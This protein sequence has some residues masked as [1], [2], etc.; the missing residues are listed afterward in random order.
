[1]P[2]QLTMERCYRGV[3]G[4]T[5]GTSRNNVDALAQ[6][7]DARLRA[8]K[9]GRPRA[10]RALARSRTEVLCSGSLP[11]VLHQE[12]NPL[13]SPLARTLKDEPILLRLGNSITL[14]FLWGCPQ[15]LIVGMRFTDHW[16]SSALF[17]YIPAVFWKF[18]RTVPASGINNYTRPR[19]GRCG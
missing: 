7:L 10:R 8:W 18:F 14:D 5:L 3:V 17:D 19:R 12:M 1:M 9:P 2:T 15:A 16:P 11:H 4:A 6:K 13:L